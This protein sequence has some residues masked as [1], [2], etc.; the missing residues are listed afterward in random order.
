MQRQTSLY[1]S[2][3]PPLFIN[4]TEEGRFSETDLI[5]HPGMIN[6]WAGAASFF[7]LIPRVC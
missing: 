4:L 6:L 5:I 2:E 3:A 1:I 7:Y